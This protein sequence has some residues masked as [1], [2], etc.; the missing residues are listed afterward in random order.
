MDFHTPVLLKEAVQLLNIQSGDQVVDCTLGGGG[1]TFLMLKKVSKKGMVLAIDADPDAIAHV[2]SEVA[3]YQLKKNLILVQENFV[4]LKKIIS[5]QKITKVKAILFDLGVSSYQLDKSE[6]GFSFKRE[7][8][9][10]MSFGTGGKN[11]ASEVINKYSKQKLKQILRDFGEVERAYDIAHRIVKYRE[12]NPIQNTSMLA[13]AVLSRFHK[14]KEAGETPFT[15]PQIKLLAKVWQAIRIEVN[16]EL[17]NLQSVLPQAMDVLTSKGRLAVISYHSLEDRIVKRFF[18]K[19]AKKCICPKDFPVCHCD[20]KPSLKIITKKPIT[21]K[22]W[23]V[24]K[25]NRARSAKLRVAEK[26]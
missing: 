4:N 24:Q 21:P 17:K 15:R 13:C 19:Q 6:K 12:K 14:I 1:H 10:N 3:D 11:K 2:E 23:Q 26:I 20:H 22:A 8:P 5:D 16:Q 7:N 25:N 18:K 9:L